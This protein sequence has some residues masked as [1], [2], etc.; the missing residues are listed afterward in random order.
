MS[1]VLQRR[2]NTFWG[3]KNFQAVGK[4]NHWEDMKEEK[5]HQ[6][7]KPPKHIKNPRRSVHILT[8]SEPQW[9]WLC[10]LQHRL[11]GEHP[12]TDGKPL[13]KSD[14]TEHLTGRT[15]HVWRT[16][17]SSNWPGWAYGWKNESVL[18]ASQEPATHI[19]EDYAMSPLVATAVDSLL[20]PTSLPI[21]WLF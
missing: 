16:G 20:I 15:A 12:I 8:V 6:Q 21:Q 14:S 7:K 13:K 18:S 19:S 1:F 17:P 10:I 4:R 9:L 2:E 3:S 11:M 5:N